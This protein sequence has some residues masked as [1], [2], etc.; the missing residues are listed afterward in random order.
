MAQ[1]SSQQPQERSDA[2]ANVTVA[3]KLPAGIVMR[4]YTKRTEREA[5]LGGGTREFDAFRWSGEEAV[6]FGTAAP[7]GQAPKCQIVAGFAITPNVKKDLFDNWYA[8]NKDGELVKRNLIFAY[9]SID[10]VHGRA[11][12]N[13]K[14]LSGFEP[15]D[16]EAPEKKVKGIARGE[17]PK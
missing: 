3:C 7:F 5:V 6:I 12:E 9:D 17:R 4:G 11:R 10:R 14:A 16:P 1:Q 13:E 15:I 8:A 2:G